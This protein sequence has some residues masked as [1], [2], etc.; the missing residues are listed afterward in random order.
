[1]RI[2]VRPSWD[3]VGGLIKREQEINFFFFSV[4]NVAGLFSLRLFS[5]FCEK[6]FL[7]QDR[8]CTGE[9]GHLE[10]AQTQGLH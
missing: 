7:H 6:S 1:M 10:D 5:L 8:L 9:R 3:R 2:R 4:A